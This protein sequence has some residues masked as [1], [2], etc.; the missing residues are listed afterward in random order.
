MG[1]AMMTLTSNL[2]LTRLTKLFPSAAK[3]F[4]ARTHLSVL[5]MVCQLTLKRGPPRG[6]R[7]MRMEGLLYNA[8]RTYSGQ[9]T[10]SL[11]A[12]TPFS[13]IS[14]EYCIPPIV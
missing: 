12:A 8:G 2:C 5:H 6:L 10:S 13:R 3:P 4:V 9:D 11:T 1:K 14:S 7:R